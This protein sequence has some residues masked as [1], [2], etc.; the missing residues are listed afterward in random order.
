MPATTAVPVIPEGTLAYGLLLP[1]VAQTTLLAQPWESSAGT[2]E[3]RRVAVAADR[4]GFFY[5]AAPDHV[6]IP[7]SHAA[8]MSTTWYDTIAT[9]GFVAAATTRVRLLSSIY[10]LPYR[11]PLMVAKA[12]ATL[13]VLSGGRVILGTGAGHVEREFETL[14]VP[15]KRRGKLLD[16][17]IDAITAAFLDEFPTHSGPT[18]TFEGVGLR[19]R[20][21]Q[22][23]RPPIWVGGSTPAALRRAAERGDGWIPQGTTREQLPAAIATIREHRA[24]TR[25]GAPIDLGAGSVLTYVGRPSFD[26]PPATRTGSGAELAAPLRELRALGVGHVPIRFVTRSCDELVAQIEAFG[27]EVAPHLNS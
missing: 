1:V 13:D 8:A 9:L 12:F 20:P 2:E 14:G 22:Q 19:P 5:V 17:S 10:V 27:A 26:V 7:K 24:R 11:H 6:C 15:F 21:V 18:W 23:P 3:I 4:A 16:E 25:G